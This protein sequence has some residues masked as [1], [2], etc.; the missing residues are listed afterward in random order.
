MTNPLNGYLVIA[1]KFIRSVCRSPYALDLWR[2][3]AEEETKRQEVAFGP[4]GHF[5]STVNEKFITFIRSSHIAR[6][7]QLRAGPDFNLFE[8]VER[9]E[10]LDAFRIMSGDYSHD[11]DGPLLHKKEGRQAPMDIVI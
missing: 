9:Y 1:D 8:K 10:I 5:S 2:A 4:S 6:H 11:V 3:R 7:V